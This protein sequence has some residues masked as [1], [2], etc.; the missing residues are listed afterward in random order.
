LVVLLLAIP[1]LVVAVYQAAGKGR[2]RRELFQFAARFGLD[3]SPTDP[4]GLIDHTF[5]LFNLGDGARCEN[6][7]RGEWN[8]VPVSA[9]EL[10]FAPTSRGLQSGQRASTKMFSFAFTEVPAWLPHIT[11]RHDPLG[12]LAEG[13]DWR[14]IRFESEA[15]NRTFAIGCEDREFAYKFVDVRML[16]WLL[17]AAQATRSSFGFEARGNRLLVHC[18]RVNPNG[19]VPVLG[20]AQGFHDSVPRMVLRQYAP[21]A[22]I[23]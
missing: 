4:V 13:L 2:R 14:R 6:V 1:V 10:R 22:P 8:G 15:F 20:M 11:I 9:G 16:Q 17:D 19:L 3:Y 21:D 12:R 7:V 5:D 23:A 18:P